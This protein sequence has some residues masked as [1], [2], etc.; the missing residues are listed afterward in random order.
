[1]DGTRIVLVRHGESVA[2]DQGIVGGH[3]GCR[4]LSD[5]GR[6]Q[7]TALR[8]RLAATGELRNAAHL[9]SSVMPRAV[10]TATILAPALEL[11][12]PIEECDL[13]EHHP[14]EGDGLTWDEFN[15]RYPVP[16]RWDPDTRRDPGGE[17]W[18]EMGDRVARGL[19]MLIERHPGET[20]VVAC[21]G[22]VVAWSMFRWFGLDVQQLGNRAWISPENASL[23][24]WRFAR[25]PFAKSTLGVQLVTFNDHAHLAASD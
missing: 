17:T 7:V 2:Q 22:G 18:A 16:K 12:E 6:R 24:E 25:N 5:K 4:G 23:T 9:Y 10:E 15:E 8:D 19:D 14:G 1:M 3:E 20:V 21:H 13:C 11:G